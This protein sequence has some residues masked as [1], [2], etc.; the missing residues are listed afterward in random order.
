MTMEETLNVKELT[1]IAVT[2]NPAKL[3]YASGQ[4]LNPNGL[5]LTLTYTDS[6]NVTSSNTVTYNS[7]T[8]NKFAFNPSGVAAFPNPNIFATIF[9]EISL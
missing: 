5:V 9:I 7:T 3:S 2:T 6:N 8:Q 4:S 1:S